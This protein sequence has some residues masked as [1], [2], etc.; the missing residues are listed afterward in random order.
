MSGS[1]SK[2]EHRETSFQ[3]ANSMLHICFLES[4][5]LTGSDMTG[6]AGKRSD[7]DS[8][9]GEIESFLD[10]KTR[11]SKHVRAQKEHG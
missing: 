4:F 9:S 2:K 3:H 11:Q 6:N 1:Y 8:R 10:G 5:N 7:Q